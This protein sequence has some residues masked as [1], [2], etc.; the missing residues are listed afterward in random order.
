MRKFLLRIGGVEWVELGMEDWERVGMRLL[1]MWGE[2]V[3]G[4]GN[5]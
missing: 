1:G 4:E 2:E 3:D 5:R